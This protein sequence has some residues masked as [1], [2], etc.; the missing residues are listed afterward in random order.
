MTKILQIG[1]IPVVEDR[2][3]NVGAG[4]EMDAVAAVDDRVAAAKVAHRPR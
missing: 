2:I 4:K 3:I 1:L